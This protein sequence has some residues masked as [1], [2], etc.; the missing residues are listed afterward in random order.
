MRKHLTSAHLLAGL[1]LF[2]AVGGSAIAAGL[3]KNSVGTKALKENAVK[4]TKIAAG[5]VTADKLADGS[6]TT[7]KLGDNA[8]TGAKAEESS[9]GQVPSAASSQNSEKLG[10]KSLSQVRPFVV[11]NTNTSAIS[12]TTSPAPVVTAPSVTIPEGGAKVRVSGTVGLG[13]PAGNVVNC[14]GD[15]TPGGGI[16]YLAQVAGVAGTGQQMPIEAT[17]DAAGG[18]TPVVRIN[19]LKTDGVSNANANSSSIHVEVFPTG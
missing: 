10:G 2:I 9:F 1:A 19:C 18:T 6:V 16:G 5:A 11:S 13:F 14:Q 3:K 12:L 4:T 15:V 8:V 7:S 17:F